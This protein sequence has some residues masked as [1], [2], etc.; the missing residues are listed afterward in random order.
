MDSQLIVSNHSLKDY[1]FSSVVLRH[2]CRTDHMC[3]DVFGGSLYRPCIYVSVTSPTPIRGRRTS[4]RLAVPP[5]LP[6]FQAQLTASPSSS[7]HLSS[8][9][10]AEGR[11]PAEAP[12]DLARSWGAV[13]TLE[14]SGPSTRRT[15]APRRS[16]RLPGQPPAR[17]DPDRFPACCENKPGARAQFQA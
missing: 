4:Q 12:A 1:S 2:L 11:L 7:F 13:L 3:V 9:R 14:P 15:N 5:P 17:E 10:A 16:A 8:S 6:S